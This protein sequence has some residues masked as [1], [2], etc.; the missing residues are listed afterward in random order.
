MK[1]IQLKIARKRER[2]GMRSCFICHIV[3]IFLSFFSE[4]V[5]NQF[6]ALKTWNFLFSSSLATKIAV[7]DLYLIMP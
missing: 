3:A 6:I 2:E 4:S 7:T 1:T 5:K